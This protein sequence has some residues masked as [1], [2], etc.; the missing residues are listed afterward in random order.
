VLLTPEDR[1]RRRRQDRT[2]LMYLGGSLGLL[3]MLL[4]VWFGTWLALLTGMPFLLL[5]VM[6]WR[7][8]PDTVCPNRVSWL[9]SGST[10]AK[11]S[12]EPERASRTGPQ[13]W[14]WPQHRPDEPLRH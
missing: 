6:A 14:D 3:S 5:A 1:L 7:E 4:A 2:I 8:Y 12:C 11:G 13:R 10:D 9:R